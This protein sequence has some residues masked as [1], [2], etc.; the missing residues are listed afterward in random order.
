MKKILAAAFVSAIVF[1]AISVNAEEITLTPKEQIIKKILQENY[2]YN[3]AGLLKAL[4]NGD[5]DCVSLFIASG[6][7]PN[8]T[9][10]KLP[11]IYWAI[12]LKK[13][14]IADKLLAAGV[15]PNQEINGKSLMALA[16]AT[17]N[18]DT[19]KVL[20]K[21]G[22]RV[23]DMST[24]KSLLTLA[25]SKKSD[26]ISNLLIKSGAEVDEQSLNK[27]LKLQNSTLKDLILT[28]YKK[29]D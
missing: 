27:A 5:T 25:L 11:A 16:I 6:M 2:N 1:G 17:E 14:D 9:I 24:G 21:H 13:P 22:A 3:S 18:V 4:K 12:K 29:Q 23:N 19:V 26:E 7:N 28:N 8:T 15:D 20:L 10:M